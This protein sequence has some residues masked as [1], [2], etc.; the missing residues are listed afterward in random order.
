[1]TQKGFQQASDKYTSVFKNHHTDK[2][3]KMLPLKQNTK[4]KTE[5]EVD[6]EMV[7]G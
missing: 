4:S 1:M 7:N 6:E 5:R 3:T 2:N